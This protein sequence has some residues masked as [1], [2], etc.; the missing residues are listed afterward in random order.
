MASV[1]VDTLFMRIL[2]S[3]QDGSRRVSFDDPNGCYALHMFRFI[4]KL[5]LTKLFQS[6]FDL[7]IRLAFLFSN[8]FPLLPLVRVAF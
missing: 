7:F 1:T 3:L 4:F 8:P 5:S 2:L 6:L